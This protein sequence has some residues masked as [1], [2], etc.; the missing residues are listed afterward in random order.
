MHVCMLSHFSHV[1]LFANLW[2]IA[3]QAPLSMGFSRQ[4]YWSGL[5]HPLQPLPNP[6]DQTQVSYVSC[7]GRRDPYH[8]CH[9]GSPTFVNAHF[10][11]NMCVCLVT[12]LCPTLCDP[13]DYSCQAPLSVKILYFLPLLT[14]C[15]LYHSFTYP[16]LKALD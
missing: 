16:S 12:Q 7:I 13:T 9:L 11:L 2:T 4:E 10:K 3:R 6:R 14:H 5:P 15:I 1:Q 8:K